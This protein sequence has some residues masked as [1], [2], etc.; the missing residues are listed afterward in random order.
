LSFGV[1]WLRRDRFARQAAVWR[2]EIRYTAGTLLVLGVQV[3][4]A[5]A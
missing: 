5:I 3:L 2:D 1:F 4:M